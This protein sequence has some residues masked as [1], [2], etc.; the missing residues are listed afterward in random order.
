MVLLRGIGLTETRTKIGVYGVLDQTEEEGSRAPHL[1]QEVY[2]ALLAV[3][4]DAS[5]SPEIVSNQITADSTLRHFLDYDPDL[6]LAVIITWS[7]DHLSVRIL[8]Q[9]PRPLVILAVPGIRSGSIVGAHQL[10]CLL[11]DLGVEHKIIYGP[12]DEQSTYAKLVAYARAAAAKRYFLNGKLGFV[13]RRTPGMTPI[14]F[15]EVEITR[16]FG[17]SVN[18]YGWEEIE[19]LARGQPIEA[20]NNTLINLRKRSGRVESTS[21]TILDS[22]RLYLSLKDLAEREGFYAYGLGC[23]PHY[24]GRVCL[25]AGL[26][27][28]DGIPTGCEGDLNAA[29]AMFLLQLFT[30]QPAHFGEILALNDEVNTFIT[31]HCGCAPP[32]LACSS[33]DITLS[34]VRIWDRGVCFRFPARPSTTATFVNLVGRKGNYRLC[35]L[36]GEAIKTQ[37]VFEGNPV[38][39]KP[40]VPVGEVMESIAQYGFGHHWMMGYSKVIEELKIFCHLTG[41]RGIFLGE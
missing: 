4:L 1:L 21:E 15:D 37:M 36:S 31:S 5:L 2:D 22:L 39:F 6:L 24:A 10:G 34:P 20:L 3:G 16:L 29:I 7:F 28:D 13:G 8:Q 40:D 38:M 41:I 14:A 18:S 26:L 35:A 11:T 25:V 9:V 19:E 27:T 32:S 30:G 33:K 23:Y 17:S 12:V